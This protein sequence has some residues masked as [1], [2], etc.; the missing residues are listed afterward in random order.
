MY[1]DSSSPHLTGDG[2][3][4]L[5]AGTLHSLLGDERLQDA[6][7]SVLWVTEVHDLVQKL[8]DQDEVVLHILLRDLA[9][10]VL[11]DLDHLEKE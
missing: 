8:V 3:L 7:V 5:L 4:L 2:R 11:H 9:E 10:I 6:G 1:H